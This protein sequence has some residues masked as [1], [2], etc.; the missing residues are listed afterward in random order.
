MQLTIEKLVYGGDGLA[1]TAPDAE[2]RRQAVFVPFVLP[3]EQVEAAQTGHG[4]GFL[5]A[6]VQYLIA[7]APQRTEPQCGY[8]RDCGGCHYQHADYP[9][10][11]EIKTAILRESLR[12]LGGIDWQDEIKVHASP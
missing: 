12:R 8:F 4:R 3:H 6:R 2:G 1:H 7:P 10:Q 11:L 5:R 9:N